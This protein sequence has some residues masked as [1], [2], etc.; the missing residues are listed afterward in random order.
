MHFKLKIL[1]LTGIDC[2]NDI[3]RITTRTCIDD[4]VDSIKNVGLINP[5][6]LRKDKAGYIIVSGFRRLA[7]CS[8]LEWSTIEA[9]II[10][11]EKTELDYVKYA[12]TDNALQR[13]LNLIE[14]SRAL[15][16]LSSFFSDDEGLV[17]VSNILGLPGNPTIIKKTES[18][19]HLPWPIQQG[20]LSNMISFSM[21]LELGKFARETGISLA[22]LFCDYKLSLNKQMEVITLIKEISAREQISPQEIMQSDHFQDIMNDSDLDRVQK[23]E[24]IKFYL[25]QRRFPE[26]TKAKQKLHKNLK[27]LK[28]GSGIKLISPKNFEDTTYT[29]QL[30]FKDFDELKDRRTKLDNIIK[31]PNL[32]T[33]MN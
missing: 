18:I 23:A 31:N 14:Q 21:A 8:C 25:N 11:P 10:V 4:L 22:K 17:E 2:S 7:A 20:I 6:L 27:N 30:S 9:R 5:P 29:L 16:M 19:C 32:K 28:L 33:I 12:I 13:P 26:I 15:K 1:P 3:Y 24:K